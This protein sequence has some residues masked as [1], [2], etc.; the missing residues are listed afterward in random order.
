MNIFKLQVRVLIK[1]LLGSH[2]VGEELQHVADAN[3]HSPD[4]WPS[5]TLLRV[6]CDSIKEMCHI[7]TL[8]FEIYHSPLDQHTRN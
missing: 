5:T 6:Y 2:P 4:T 1:N 7:C 3:S 8:S